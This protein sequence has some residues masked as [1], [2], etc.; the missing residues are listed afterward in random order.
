MK[1]KSLSLINKL[2]EERRRLRLEEGKKYA[3]QKRKYLLKQDS[4]RKL[5]AVQVY[6]LI[7]ILLINIIMIS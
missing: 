5:K 4:D 1:S 3:E 2:D 7:I 6:Y